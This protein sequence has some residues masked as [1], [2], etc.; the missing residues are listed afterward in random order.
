MLRH[1]A[2]ANKRNRCGFFVQ[3]EVFIS[4]FWVD[5]A[6]YW[7]MDL[8]LL[9][10]QTME[11]ILLIL[12]IAAGLGFVDSSECTRTRCGNGTVLVSK[13]MYSY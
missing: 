11:N 2:R 6:Q 9:V 12:L 3:F 13:S 10:L 4:L 5:Q 7:I 8:S 1:I